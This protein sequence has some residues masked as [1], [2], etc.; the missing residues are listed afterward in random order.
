M[1]SP[2]L[3]YQWDTLLLEVS[4]LAV[5]YAPH[6]LRPELYG[7][8]EPSRLSEWMLKLLLF[9]LIISSGLVKLRSG[10]TSWRDLSALDYH[11]WTQPI[12][13]QLS[14]YAHHLGAEVRR[15]GVLLNH[16]IELC[17]PWLILFPISRALLIPWLVLIGTLL[18]VY[19]DELSIGLTLVIGGL[20]ALMA[21]MSLYQRSRPRQ[22]SKRDLSWIHTASATATA[23]IALLMIN[24]ALTGNYGFFNLLTIA[25]VFPCVHQRSL[26]RL[27]PHRLSVRI[28]HNCGP[29]PSSLWRGVVLTAALFL[30][31]LNMSRL[32][33]L[34]AHTQISQARALQTQLDRQSQ[35][36]PARAP[37]RS[38][39]TPTALSVTQR[40]WFN[41]YRLNRESLRAWG[42][43]LLVNSYGLFARMTQERYELIIEGSAE[44]REW[45]PYRFKYKPNDTNEL[46]FAGAH[47]PR[48]D[49]QMWF[50]ALYPRCRHRWFFGLL[51][52]LLEGSPAVLS[53]FETSPFTQ[54]P[55]R[56]LRVRRVS[57]QF[58]TSESRSLTEQVWTY[59]AARDYCPII[60]RAQLR[61]VDTGRR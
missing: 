56:Y 4:V 34:F 52:A 27:I 28:P 21:L 3:G 19:L 32:A 11:F 47:M 33:Q 40:A 48:L 53:L 25:L 61:R 42:S 7:E 16:F 12:P 51:D 59:K 1:A 30:I 24:V 9:K 37:D 46:H 15:L 36:V 8:R 35:E 39:D 20:T 57:A 45:H 2:F 43:L 22:H 58:T 31:P 54:T 60:D 13:H 38:H 55:P 26:S 23:L 14:W 6:T 17:I 18:G 44:G 5:F 10:D 29:P 50:A 49:W 41:L